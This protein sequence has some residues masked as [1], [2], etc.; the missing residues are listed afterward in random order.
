[1]GKIAKL[2]LSIVEWIISTPKGYLFFFTKPA[3]RHFYKIDLA[4]I[5]LKVIC[6]TKG[7]LGIDLVSM[8]Q[9]VSRSHSTVAE[10]SLSES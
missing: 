2:V 6:L 9:E 1:M 8:R 4:V 3:N 7:A 10:T 5:N